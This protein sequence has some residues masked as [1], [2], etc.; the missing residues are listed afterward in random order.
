MPIVP[1]PHCRAEN[2]VAAGNSPFFCKA[3]H[4]IVDRTGTLRQPPTAVP[5][6]VAPQRNPRG[7]TPAPP[8]TRSMT[9]SAG[10]INYHVPSGP[11]AGFS[12]G[13]SRYVGFALAA[14]AAAVAGGGLA[15]MGV[16]VIRIPLLYPFIAAWAIRRALATGSGGGTPDRGVFGGI[17]LAALAISTCV[18]ARFGEYTETA[19]RE[20]RHYGAIYGP[21]AAAAMRDVK[22]TEAA[23][24]ALDP[25]NDGTAT[26]SAGRVFSVAEEL[27]H[28]MTAH[29][30][31]AVPSDPYDIYLLAVRGRAGFL[32]H[33]Q[34][35]L[36]EGDDVRLLPSGKGFHLPGPAI[37]ALWLLEILI[38]LIVAF[39]RID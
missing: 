31:N 3:C 17:F 12:V 29:A 21:S 28:V 15:W 10:S 37:G 38:V 26:T 4:A 6:A 7:D 25:D 34:T 30:T 11:G 14:L 19:A 36:S 24:R 13:G 32:G 22:A 8:S 18:A 20:S 1:C 16:N 23:I 35:V 27:R 33:L 39:G 2:D 9:A 5:A